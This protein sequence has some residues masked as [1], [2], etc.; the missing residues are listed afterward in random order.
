MDSKAWH[1]IET[2]GVLSELNTN[3]ETGLSDAEVG[4]RAQKYG[5][6]E[7]SKEEKTSAFKT[8]INQFNNVLV[9]IL[10]V[11]IVLSALVGEYIDAGIIALI[12]FF[13]A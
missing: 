1:A 4:I 11:A 3:S 2:A 6:N 5:L 10:L 12:V 13:V 9:I 8:F 7:L